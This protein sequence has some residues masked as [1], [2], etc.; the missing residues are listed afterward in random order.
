MAALAYLQTP[1][2][3]QTRRVLEEITVVLQCFQLLLLLVAVLAPII[4]LL[5]VP[6]EAAAALAQIL[7]DNKV[8]V[9]PVKAIPA[10]LAMAA[11]PVG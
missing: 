11:V 9:A 10:G 5:A 2:A 3:A 1:Q 8:L 7:Q 4:L 6:A